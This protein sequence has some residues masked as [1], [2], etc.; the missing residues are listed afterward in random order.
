MKKASPIYNALAALAKLLHD[1]SAKWIVGGSAGLLL[2]GLPLSAMPRDIDIYCDEEDLPFIY[3]ALQ[4]YAVDAPHYSETNM[5]RSTLAHFEIE[6]MPIELVGGFKV[7]AAKS[8]Y[9]VRV[10]ELLIPF[11]ERFS[12]PDCGYPLMVV[13]LAHELWFNQ[14][15]GREDRVELIAKAFMKMRGIHEPALQAIEKSNHFT[16]AAVD[17]VHQIISLEEAGEV[18]WTQR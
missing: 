12:I 4:K 7:D 10:S 9:E 18:E 17:Q 14:L 11:G 1:S 2:R 3:A 16:A 8:S 5:Y 15:R 13:P 6:G